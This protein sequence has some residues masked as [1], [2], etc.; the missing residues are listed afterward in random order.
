[1]TNEYRIFISFLYENIQSDNELDMVIYNIGLVQKISEQ[2]AYFYNQK[3][4]NIDKADLID[5][6]TEF[7]NQCNEKI[8]L[9]LGLGSES[10]LFVQCKPIS[11][12]VQ[13]KNKNIIYINKE[14]IAQLTL[15]CM[16]NEI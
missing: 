15:E 13:Q 11:S 9:V 6:Q 5:F 12:D 10:S 7:E 2:F 14:L 16:R 3:I 4:Q 1:M 8:F